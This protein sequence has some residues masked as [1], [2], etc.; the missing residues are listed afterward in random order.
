MI[1]FRFGKNPEYMKDIVM[2]EMKTNMANTEELLL[3]AT[4]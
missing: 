2:S 1:K 3:N 4:M